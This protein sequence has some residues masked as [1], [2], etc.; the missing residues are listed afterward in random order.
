MK[1]K[2]FD[3][4]AA[5]LGTQNFLGARVTS[6]MAGHSRQH[7][8]TRNTINTIIRDAVQIPDTDLKVKICNKSINGPLRW[9]VIILGPHHKT[10]TLNSEQIKQLQK[11]NLLIINVTKKSQGLGLQSGSKPS[12]FTG[13]S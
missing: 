5:D 7:L 1:E 10:F 8:E 11:I 4:L 6:T 2:Y 9:V 12:R 13:K 3:D